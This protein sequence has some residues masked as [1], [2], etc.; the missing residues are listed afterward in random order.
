EFSKRFKTDEVWP[1]ELLAK[2]PEY[3]GKTLY[4]VLYANGAVNKF[5]KQP[6]TDDRG[7]VYPNDEMDAF[8]FYLQK[9]L[10]EEYRIFGLEGP[11]KG[12]DLAAFDQYHQARG[13]RWP[14]VD[15]KETLWRYREG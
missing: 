7:N 4:E 6:V 1:E 8:G 13:L 11:K 14:V 2:N 10:F 3:R 15:G 12:H 9:G 5:A